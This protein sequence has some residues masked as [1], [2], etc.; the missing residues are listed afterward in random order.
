MSTQSKV[1]I[2]DDEERNRDLLEAILRPLGFDLSTADNG[3]E[4]LAKAVELKPDLILLD[5]M[6][7]DLSGFEVCQQLRKSES[8]ADIPIIMVTALDDRDSRIQG[9]EAGADDFISKP[10]DRVE[11]K[12]RVQTV[13]KLNRFRRLLAEREK[14]ER[15]AEFASDAFLLLTNE[16][17]IK[18][19]NGRAAEVMG[20]ES[21]IGKSFRQAVAAG[22]ALKP[23]GA[24][25][26]WLGSDTPDPGAVRYLVKIKREDTEST[27]L[28]S[29]LF[30][31]PGTGD[32]DWLVRLSDITQVVKQQRDSWNFHHAISNKLHPSLDDIDEQLSTLANPDVVLSTEDRVA[33]AQNALSVSRRL[34]A[35]LK[36]IVQY[37]E[38]ASVSRRGEQVKTSAI[39]YKAKFI[40]DGHGVF[41][42]SVNT[43]EDLGDAA[44]GIGSHGVET[45]LSELIENSQKFHPRRD[46]EI[47]VTVKRAN[48]GDIA[49]IVKD[50]GCHL[51]AQALQHATEPYFQSGAA[52]EIP[53]MGL[54]L[55]MISSIIWDFGGNLT[56]K[57]RADCPGVVAR[58]T[59]P[60]L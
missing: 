3:R 26:N 35:Q 54:G 19:A 6:M 41:Q 33:S 22:F 45:I 39:G 31:L 5:V 2:V 18:Y 8:T 40:A 30:S 13:T 10:V 32:A 51:D 14:F 47:E 53:G 24:W 55:A 43:A 11:L 48:S 1:L 9:I 12:T 49:I 27:W 36:D 42:L 34:E 20:G 16:G 17:T 58:V 28:K 60:C 57:N 37:V 46:P 7:P 59:L 50:N 56:L 23:R 15:I 21:L 4:A 25:E 52:G 44:I 38:S 29:E